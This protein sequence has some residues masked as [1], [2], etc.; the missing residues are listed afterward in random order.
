MTVP[1]GRPVPDAQIDP[2][3]FEHL[4]QEHDPADVTPGGIVNTPPETWPDEWTYVPGESSPRV[5]G[6]DA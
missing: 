2:T 1:K 5:E 3:D 6:G 4:E